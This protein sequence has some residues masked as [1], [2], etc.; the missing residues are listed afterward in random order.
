[1]INL[2]EINIGNKY[3]GVEKHIET[4]IKYID[5]NEFNL[6][7]VC[8]YNSYFHKRIVQV[9]K[10]DKI[11]IIPIEI[12][13]ASLV[14][15]LKNL[16]KMI[17]LNEIEIIHTHGIAS[18]FIGNI[19]KSNSN[20]LITTV[21]GYSNYDRLEKNS[22]VKFIFDKSETILCRNSDLCIAVSN[23]IKRYLLK[24]RVNENKI[25]VIHHGI[26]YRDS[27]G[28]KK[29]TDNNKIKIIS[30]GRL[31]KVK[32]YKT[33]IKA[34]KECRDNGYDLN[35]EIAGSGED[36]KQLR[37]LISS[38]GLNENCKLLGFINDIDKFLFGGDIYV[39]SSLIESFGISIIEAMQ[40]GL[41]VIASNIGGIKDI[42]SN[43]NDGILFEV[44]NYKELSNKIIEL[45]ENNKKREYIS[46]KGQKKVNENFLIDKKIDELEVE[47][48]KLVGDKN[49]NSNN[50]FI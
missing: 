50:T 1:M 49:E 29:V 39:Q 31:D 23:D 40:V 11:K 35:C 14:K 18:S 15:V 34:I 4:I 28:I 16:K 13:L 12:K 47:I 8:R 25:K 30:L 26:N 33:L 20:I 6:F 48:K 19:I 3:G 9:I 24:K 32:D 2:L 42:I 17:K 43:D 7:I 38:L 36:E 44:G 41:P 45:I 21:H 10:D 5:K 37:E 22:L 27:Y 46:Y